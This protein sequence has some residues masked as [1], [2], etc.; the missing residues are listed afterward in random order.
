MIKRLS[1]L[2]VEGTTQ[3]YLFSAKLSEEHIIAYHSLMLMPGIHSIVVKNM[4]IGRAI[5]LSLVKSLGYYHNVGCLSLEETPQEHSIK[6]VYYNLIAGD[7]LNA[8][9]GKSIQDFLFEDFTTCDFLWIEKTTELENA[10]WYNYFYQA[11][12]PHANR[13]PIFVLGNI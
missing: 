11:L 10:L 2:F 6:D 4:Q 9:S 1:S 8:H 5:M 7:Y 3:R 13:L 12:L